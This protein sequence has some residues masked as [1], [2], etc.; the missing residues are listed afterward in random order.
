MFQTGKC[1]LCG[2]RLKVPNEAPVISI[3]QVIYATIRSLSV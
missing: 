2:T 1:S 3:L